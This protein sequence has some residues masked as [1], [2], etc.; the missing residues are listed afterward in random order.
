MS[1]LSHP[2]YSQPSPQLSPPTLK[3]Q[4]NRAFSLFSIANLLRYGSVAIVML[5]VL[6]TSS[7]LIQMSARVQLN[8]NQALQQERSHTV[9]QSIETY[10]HNFQT[11]LKYL[12]RV[13][14]LTT[15]PQPV[16]HNLLEGLT[17]LDDAY[18]AIGIF[19][20]EGEALVGI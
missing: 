15:L 5:C 14:G 3:K 4:Q 2:H 6:L 9:A 18:E 1:S 12:E 7:M 16:Q 13:R 8:D 11:E 10:L 20:L 17:R 19:N